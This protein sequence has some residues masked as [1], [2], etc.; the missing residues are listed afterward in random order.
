MKVR[1][2]KNKCGGCGLCVSIAPEVFEFDKDGKSKVKEKA[3][4]Q[5]NK[6]LINQAK[7]SC[8]TQAIEVEE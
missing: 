7:E 3:D 2:D 5:K 4:L 6:E 8:P 1:V